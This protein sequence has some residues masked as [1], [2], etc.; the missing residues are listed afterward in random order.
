MR[1]PLVMVTA[2]LMQNMMQIYKKD[3]YFV[4]KLFWGNFGINSLGALGVKS[5]HGGAIRSRVSCSL[6]W[7]S[8]G[9]FLAII[10][11]SCGTQA[12][13]KTLRV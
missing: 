3:A 7:R 9:G 4:T 8:C 6:V 13:D 12:L 1:E 2:S 5:P 11:H 10:Y